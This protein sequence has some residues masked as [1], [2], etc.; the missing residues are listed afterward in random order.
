MNRFFKLVTGLAIVSA[1]LGGQAALACTGGALTA[2][3]GSTVVG[4]TLEF[5][6]SLDSQI[7]VWPK[8][9]EFTGTT[10]SG[11]NGVKFTAK[12][13]FMGATV[14]T[15]YDMVVDGL[16]EKGLNA[17][18][19][20][21]P[22]Y[23]D[24]T[25]ATAQNTSKGISPAQFVTWLLANFATVDEVK[26]HIDQVAVLP[27][28]LDLLK[29]VPDVHYKV[30]D[31]TGKAITIEPVGG[32]LKVYDNPVRVLTNSPGFDFHLTNLNNYLN[33]T[34]SYLSPK[35]VGDL[36]LQPFGMG[37]GAVGL[38]GDITPPSRF[39]RMV[40]YTQ[41]V[42]SLPNSEA[43]VSTLF[44]LLNN[45]DIPYGSSEPPPGTA[46]TEPEITTWTA[47][48]DLRKLQF[49]WKTYGHQNVRVIDLREA[50]KQANGKMLTR[51]M[52]PQ[53]ADTV[54]KSTPV[55]MK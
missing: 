54:S 3:D 33:V 21:F 49:H 48:S 16:N 51:E 13:G 29:A 40:F 32:T 46:E 52:G 12:H 1:T 41:N 44:H 27:V 11:N 35:K 5:G 6:T 19:F 17:A 39:L 9:S 53:S 10:P 15:H 31:A 20:Y 38:P 7:V 2:K 26:A 36:T 28:V 23:A 50:L 8:G 4:R 45:F 55:T 42:P 37:G 25:K 14:G 22:G 24:Y 47:V 18:L 34:S 43:A 30:Q